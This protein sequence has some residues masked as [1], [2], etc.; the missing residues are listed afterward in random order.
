MVNRIWTIFFL[1]VYIYT[2]NAEDDCPSITKRNQW[3][4]VEA[5][6]VNY[7]I[8]PIPYVVIIHTVTPECNTKRQCST[9]IESLRSHHMD[10]LGWHDI[11]FSFLIGGDGNVYEGTGWNREGAHTYGYNKKAVGIA[12]IGDYRRKGASNEMLNATHNLILCGKSQ[13]ILRNDV[14]VVG[15]RQVISTE[16]PGIELYKQIQE[17]PEWSSNP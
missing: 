10:I 2:A 6:D 17:W 9:Q 7:L 11:G 15:A 16:S 8:L 4:T 1:I 3:S 13:G 12:F 14:R 5:R